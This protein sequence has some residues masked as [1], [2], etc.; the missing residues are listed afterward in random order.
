MVK[1][2]DRIGNT[3]EMLVGNGWIKGIIVNGER[4]GD[5][6][7]NM[8]NADGRKYWCGVA[9]SCY[10]KTDDSLGDLITQA[11]RIRSMSDE[12]L[13]EFLKKFDLCTNCKY[14]EDV[15]CTFENPCT[16][17]FATAMAYEWL[18]SEVKE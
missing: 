3:I 11:D 17:G 7:I 12:E 10:R 4:T 2:Y 16:H 18:K 15:R 6:I 5:G 13:A 1:W 9:S 8:E 14:G